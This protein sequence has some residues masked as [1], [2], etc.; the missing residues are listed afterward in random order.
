MENLNKV[1]EFLLSTLSETKDF[2][3]EQAPDYVRQMLEFAAFEHKMYLVI[4][5]L[6]FLISLATLINGV[7]LAMKP[8]IDDTI[9]IIIPSFM[10][11]GVATILFLCL[12]INRFVQLKKLEIAPKIYLMEQIG[13]TLKDR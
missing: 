8:V 3:V 7:R 2:I 11:G 4:Y 9:E 1:T 13:R 12:S 6:L 5:S 10:I